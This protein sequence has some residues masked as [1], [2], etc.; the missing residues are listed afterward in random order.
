MA[1]GAIRGWGGKRVQQHLGRFTTYA[2]QGYAYYFA[3]SSKILN[4][5]FKKIMLYTS[6][7]PGILV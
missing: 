7:A 5:L 2:K 1:R 4:I 6:Q 3:V